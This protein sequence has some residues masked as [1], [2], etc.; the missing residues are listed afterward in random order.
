MDY[1]L[2][3]SGNGSHPR[4]TMRA[5]ILLIGPGFLCASWLASSGC[6]GDDEQANTMTVAT[7][8]SPAVESSFMT[9]ERE[10]WHEFEAMHP[11]SRV[12]VEQIPGIGQYRTKVIMMH[13]SDCMPDVIL[14]DASTAAVFLDNGVVRDL[15]PYME[16]DPNFRL[17]D[18]FPQVVDVYR[19]ENAVYAVPLDFTP[20]VMYYNKVLFDKANVPYPRA[21]WS[22][23]DFLRIAQQLTIRPDPAKPPVQYG[24]N[25]ENEMPFWLL[26]L[27][28]NGGDVLSPDGSHATGYFD[29]PKSI[30]ALQFL[31]DLSLKYHVAPTLTERDSGGV[32]LFLDGR[33]AMDLKGHWMMI[34][35]KARNLDVGIVPLPTHGVPPSTVAYEVGLAI[36][37]KS[38]NPDLAWEYIKFITS[39]RVQVRRVGAGLAISGNR[40]AAAQFAGN[41]VEDEFLRIVQYARPPWGAIVERYDACQVIG[42][43]MMKEIHYQRRPV[44]E[45]AHEAAVLMD[46]ALVRP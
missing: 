34:D 8:G 1:R 27:W 38:K 37:T 25:F 12:M 21:G 23:D 26:W 20:M 40:R 35:Y 46:G 29:G 24:F 33:A 39:E 22:W 2:G 16:R 19:R 42:A 14:V 28:T 11:G 41:P 31:S 45:A 13:V 10:L 18:Y 17:N 44:A 6:T 7:W 30:A 15:T 32:D 9:L 4:I 43:E 36:T 3:V 5:A